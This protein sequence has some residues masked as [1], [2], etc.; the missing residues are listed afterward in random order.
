MVESGHPHFPPG[1]GVCVENDSVTAPVFYQST[2]QGGVDSV[3]FVIQEPQYILI[4]GGAAHLGVSFGVTFF[5]KPGDE[6]TTCL[7]GIDLLDRKPTRDLLKLL[8]DSSRTGLPKTQRVESGGYLWE[9]TV[10]G[11]IFTRTYFDRT[12]DGPCSNPDVPTFPYPGR[13]VAI[14]H[15]HPYYDGDTLPSNCRTPPWPVGEVHVVDES[16]FG[17]PSPHDI[18]RLRDDN[19]IHNP[20]PMLIVDSNLVFFVPPGT[21]KDSAT[22]QVQRRARINPLNSCSLF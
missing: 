14:L 10:T 4:N 3:L 9:D 15:S 17:G 19:A 22:K 5:E 8:W 20:I 16:T 13:F 18:D 21:T 2:Y 11:T 7:T 1:G 12:K 6:A